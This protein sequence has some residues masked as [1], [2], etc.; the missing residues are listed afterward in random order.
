MRGGAQGHE[1]GGRRERDRRGVLG[2]ARDSDRTAYARELLGSSDWYE[3]LWRQRERLRRIPALL[4]WGLADPAF[5]RLL[6]R[7]RAVFDDAEVLEL[8]EAGHAPPEERAPELLPALR[9]FLDR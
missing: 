1:L 9:R 7:W 3:G 5:G 8:P 4:A 2:G 6:P